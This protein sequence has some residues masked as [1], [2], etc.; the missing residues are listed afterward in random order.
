MTDTPQEAGDCGYS[1]RP[2]TMR[3]ERNHAVSGCSEL[4]KL[5]TCVP[6]SDCGA[7]SPNVSFR[8]CLLPS[9]FLNHPCS[10]VGH[11][12]ATNTDS[13]STFAACLA[14]GLGPSGSHLVRPFGSADPTPRLADTVNGSSVGNF[15]PKQHPKRMCSNANQWA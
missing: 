11:P 7:S 4:I 10:P 2:R 14:R 8:F 15:L 3:Q 9:L 5:V 12:C 13:R 6:W 1:Y